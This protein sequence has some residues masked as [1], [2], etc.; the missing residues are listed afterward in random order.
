MEVLGSGGGGALSSSSIPQADVRIVLPCRGIGS[1]GRGRTGVRM[2]DRALGCGR[3]CRGL[4]REMGQ[5]Q[6]SCKG[7]GGALS[8]SSFPPVDVRLALLQRGRVRFGRR[9]LEHSSSPSY[10]RW[11]YAPFCRV[12]AVEVLR[13]GWGRGTLLI[14]CFSGGRTPYFTAMWM[15]RFW[16]GEGVGA[17]AG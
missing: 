7:E 10:C 4:G 2:R 9:G 6:G 17:G 1:S 15:R 13:V 14:L 3:T 16:K 12:V 5:G 11:M 8:F